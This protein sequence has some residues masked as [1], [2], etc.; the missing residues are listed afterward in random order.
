MVK[1][2]NTPLGN[3]RMNLHNYQSP[4]WKEIFLACTTLQILGRPAI[5]KAHR[6]N[7]QI[8]NW[9]VKKKK[10]YR[11]WHFKIIFLTEPCTPMEIET[12]K[13]A[14]PPTQPTSKRHMTAMELLQTEI[15]YVKI[16]DTIINV[17]WHHPGISSLWGG[18]V[19][20]TRAAIFHIFTPNFWRFYYNLIHSHLLPISSLCKTIMYIYFV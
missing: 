3:I 18:G 2:L 17:S 6:V 8:L 13:K 5:S 14:A 20:L 7:T 1:A 15:N 10:I 16:L 9:S 4:K 19:P 12:P 11:L